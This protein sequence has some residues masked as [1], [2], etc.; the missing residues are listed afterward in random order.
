MVFRW[1]GGDRGGESVGVIWMALR[2]AQR[3]HRAVS[4]SSNWSAAAAATSAAAAAPAACAARGAAGSRRGRGRG[5]AVAA[6]ALSKQDELKM[7]AAAK[8]VESVRSGMVVGLGTG[9]TAAFAVDRLGELLKSGEIKDVVGVPTSNAT[10]QQARGLGIP[11][12]TL[13]DYPRLDIAIDGADEVDGKLGYARR[14][15]RAPS[16]GSA[17]GPPLT[18]PSAAPGRAAS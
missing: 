6:M 9:S 14:R 13:D 11:L 16:R 1:R 2:A 4:S 8:A 18:R 10:E 15:A 5:R 3:G 12:G 17:R 7:A